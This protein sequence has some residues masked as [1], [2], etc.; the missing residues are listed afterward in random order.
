MFI[1][2]TIRKGKNGQT[3]NKFMYIPNDYTQNYPFFR[4]QLFVETF[5][6]ST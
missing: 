6:H 3:S 2:N 1:K 4:L 5:V